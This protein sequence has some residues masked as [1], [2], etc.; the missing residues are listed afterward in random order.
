MTHRS[1]GWDRTDGVAGAAREEFGARGYDVDETIGLVA[2]RLVPHARE[3]RD[4]AIH[5]LDS[6]PGADVELWDGVLEL[7]VANRDEG[8]EEQRYRRVHAAAPGRAAR[9]LPAGTR[10]LV[11]RG[12]PGDRSRRRELRDRRDR[13]AAGG[14]RSWTP[15]PTTSAAASRR[16]SSS[17]RHAARRPTTARSASSSPPTRTTTRS[18]C[19]SRSAS[20]AA[21]TSSASASGRGRPGLEP[22]LQQPEDAAHDLA[23]ELLA[24]ARVEEVADRVRAAERR[25]R[26][27]LL[28]ARAAPAAAPRAAPAARG[29]RRAARARSAR[30]RASRTSRRAAR[31]SRRRRRRR[32]GAMRETGGRSRVW[33]TGVGTPFSERIVTA[34]SPIPSC[35][36]SCSRS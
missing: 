10:R 26:G 3:N 34:A 33:T 22:L 16:G 25:G 14:S 6:A 32:P 28:L 5:T 9:D 11:R 35:W 29:A 12:R 20:S 2:E 1:F 30:R 7:Q 21:S 19:T 31:P 8:H 15:P 13:T 36:S 18:A 27:L 4:V 24:R 23:L 17:R